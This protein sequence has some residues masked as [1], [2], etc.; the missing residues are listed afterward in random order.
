MCVFIPVRQNQREKPAMTTYSWVTE[1]GA[2]SAEPFAMT[3][4]ESSIGERPKEV[5]DMLCWFR[6]FREIQRMQ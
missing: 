3:Y 2:L 6:P 4:V 1:S 5:V